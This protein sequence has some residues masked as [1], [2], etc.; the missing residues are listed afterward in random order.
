[1]TPE[2]IALDM[3]EHATAIREDIKKIRDQKILSEDVVQ[4]MAAALG[5][6]FAYSFC[7]FHGATIPNKEKVM[8]LKNW[9][10]TGKETEMSHGIEFQVR[11]WKKEYTEE[12]V[13]EHLKRHSFNPEEWKHSVW[14]DGAMTFDLP[15]SGTT[16]ID[17]KK[18]RRLK[19][20][21]KAKKLYIS[22]VQLEDT[23]GN[24]IRIE[25]FWTKTARRNFIR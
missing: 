4:E 12:D 20:I 19:K 7:I 13:R 11:S 1:M 22:P 8:G 21:F 10:S 23:G 18:L 2:E 5:S 16:R 24:G 17:M 3:R 25:L 9:E 6:I 14:G 15:F